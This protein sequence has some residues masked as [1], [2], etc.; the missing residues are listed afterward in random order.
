MGNND[1]AKIR[2]DKGR[3][4]QMIYLLLALLLIA[5]SPAPNPVS[6]DY[7]CGTRAHA[8]STKPLTCC[9]NFEEC[10]HGMCSVYRNN[11]ATPVATGTLNTNRPNGITLGNMTGSTSLPFNGKMAYVLG[12]NQNLTGTERARLFGFWSAKYGVAS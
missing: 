5:C 12:V 10:D 9:W 2:C 4:P 11:A 1:A 7:P 8:C 3:G 6:K